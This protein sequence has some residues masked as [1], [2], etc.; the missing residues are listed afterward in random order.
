MT[1][2]RVWDENDDPFTARARPA[3]TARGRAG[4]A[5]RPAPRRAA[6]PHHR[7]ARSAAHHRRSDTPSSVEGR[8][9]CATRRP[10]AA[11]ALGHEPESR[12]ALSPASA[13]S[14]HALPAVSHR[15]GSRSRIPGQRDG[16]RWHRCLGASRAASGRGGARR[17]EH[18]GW[19]ARC[20]ARR[21]DLRRTASGSGLRRQADATCHPR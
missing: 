2:Y 4:G 7:A 16:A 12:P 20:L 13:A 6:R 3:R 21:R 11:T 8:G 18:S 17:R 1:V 14:G 5:R 9:Q 15:R 19:L 10:G